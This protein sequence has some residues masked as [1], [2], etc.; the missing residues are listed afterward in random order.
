MYYTIPT[1][2]G[3]ILTISII[4]VGVM[5]TI[6]NG[7]SIANK[8]LKKSI[9]SKDEMI[10]TLDLYIH[11]LREEIEIKDAALSAQK[12]INSKMIDKNISLSSDNLILLNNITWFI[13]SV[14][15]HQANKAIAYLRFTK[16]LEAL[17]VSCPPDRTDNGTKDTGSRYS[18]GQASNQA[19]IP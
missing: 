16:C 10:N 19:G 4:I 11:D 9:S 6:I 18:R 15:K 3:I 7:Y 13:E 2:I 12:E 14:D 17:S 1:N 8:E 5:L